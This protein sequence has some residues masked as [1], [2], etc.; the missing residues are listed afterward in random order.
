MEITN[1][2]QKS[3]NPNLLAFGFPILIRALYPFAPHLTADLWYKLYDELE[4]AEGERYT[5]TQNN[6]QLTKILTTCDIRTPNA[7]TSEAMSSNFMQQPTSELKVSL[8]GK[9]LGILKVD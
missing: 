4:G 9:F 8:N 2:L 5:I 6:A 7:F 1:I 3:E